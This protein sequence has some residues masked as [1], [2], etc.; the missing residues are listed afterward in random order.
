MFQVGVVNHF[1]RK[2]KKP[3]AESGRCW[4]LTLTW[5]EQVQKAS[6]GNSLQGSAVKRRV[7]RCWPEA[8]GREG[9]VSGDTRDAGTGKSQQR[10]KR[11]QQKTC[12]E[13]KGD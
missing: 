12:Q 8:G 7:M 13:R 4:G 6:T 9:G 1:K 2:T 11:G 5:G 10:I 3:P